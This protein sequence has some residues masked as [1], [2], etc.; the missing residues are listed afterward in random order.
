MRLPLLL[1][2]I[3]ML[4]PVLLKA[5]VADQTKPYQISGLIIS[6]TSSEAIPYVRIQVNHSRRGAISND[7]GFYSIPVSIGDTL[8]FTH[9]GFDQTPF[10]I[11][12]YLASYQNNNSQYIYAVH[13]M[14]EDTFTLE[15][16]F[17]F[18]YDTPEELKTAVVNM[19]ILQM[20]PEA[21]A[22]R[23]LD[24]DVLHAIIQTL[25]KDGGERIMVGRQMYYDYYQNRNLL[26]TVGLD[27]LAA[28]RLLQYVV[29]KTKKRKN[30]D[31]NYWE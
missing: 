16:V 13:Y 30:K 28:M 7:E 9:I 21:I 25:P 12:D 31:L 8:Y 27:P 17:I 10:I 24:P 14:R 2:Y 1:A 18:P 20:S 23:N 22:R 26:P 29:N 4:C 11:K 3:C 15:D 5:Q 6:E 19:D